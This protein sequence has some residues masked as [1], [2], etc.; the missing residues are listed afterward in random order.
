MDNKDNILICVDTSYFLYY[1]IFGAVSQFQKKYQ[2]E[3]NLLIKPAD[4]TD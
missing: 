1:T 4:E 3:A 2:H